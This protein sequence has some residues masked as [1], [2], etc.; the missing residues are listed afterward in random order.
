MARRTDLCWRDTTFVV[1]HEDM[2][3]ESWWRELYGN[4]SQG[5]RP[6]TPLGSGR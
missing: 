3:S 6:S 1:K 5:R 2:S 4:R